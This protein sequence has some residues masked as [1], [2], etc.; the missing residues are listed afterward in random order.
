MHHIMLND[1]PR[2]VVFSTVEDYIAWFHLMKLKINR[3]RIIL[4]ALIT[5]SQSKAKLLSQIFDGA[6]DEGT[7]VQEKGC[8]VERVTRLAISLGV[9]HAEILLTL[10]YELLSE[11]VF[12]FLRSI[13]FLIEGLAGLRHWFL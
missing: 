8:V 10:P 9:W 7:A 3:Q 6:S 13:T 12:E 11:P 2:L 1:S 5:R 4:V